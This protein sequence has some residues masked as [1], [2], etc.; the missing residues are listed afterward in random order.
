MTSFYSEEELSEL[1]FKSVGTN[2]LLSRKASIY[3]ASKT[4]IGNNVR[5]DDFCVLSISGELIIGDYVHIGCH[6]SLIGKGLIKVSDFCGISGHVCIYSS[7]DDFSGRYLT[8]PMVDERFT[9]VRHAPV[10]LEKHVIIGCASV[11]MPGVTLEEGVAIGAMSFVNMNCKSNYIYSGNPIKKL[12][13]RSK[14]Y[15]DLEI[16]FLQS[17]ES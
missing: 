7:C 8:N 6:T 17:R 12:I 11:V 10:I 14:K 16:E 9:N 15:K 5:I 13:P 1:G 4:S 3:G 2:V